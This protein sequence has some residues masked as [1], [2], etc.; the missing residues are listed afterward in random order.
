MEHRVI[1]VRVR[2]GY[3]V[4]IGRGL[5]EESGSL[6]RAAL[7]D[8]RLALVT[9]SNVADLYLE[10]VLTSLRAAGYAVNPFVFAA[11][12]QNKNMQTLAD[13]LEFFAAERLTRTDCVLALG[14]VAGLL[15]A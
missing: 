8:C 7:G 2:E 10:R 6:L 3:N 12:E 14:G 13:V 15:L 9:D 5:L 11:G 1:P 4:V